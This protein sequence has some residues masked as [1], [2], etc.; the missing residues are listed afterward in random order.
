M[1]KLVD[2]KKLIR[3]RIIYVVLTFI[4]LVAGGTLGWKFLASELETRL[5]DRIE[6]LA[7]QGKVFQC[8]DQRVEG[9]P[10]RVGLFCDDIVFEDTARKIILKAG[11]FRSAA[12][13]YQPGFIVGEL[14]S[15][16]ELKLAQLGGFDLRWKLARSSTRLSLG[17]IRSISVNLEDFSAGKLENNPQNL[18]DIKLSLLELHLRAEGND[19]ASA[20]IEVAIELRDIRVENF[21]NGSFPVMN[22]IADGIVTDL[23]QALNSGRDL[24]DWARE[25]GLKL[26]MRKLEF[27]LE[28]GGSLL[29]S[30]PVLIDSDGLVSGKLSVEVTGFEDLVRNFSSQNSQ[31]GKYAELL[32]NASAIFAQGAENKKIRLPI[33]ISRGNVSAGFIPLG[34]IPPLY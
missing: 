15:P 26:Q 30:G 20:D 32:Q 7:K 17:G 18:P 25:N 19:P 5:H 23:N 34:I 2:E 3:R 11:K 8:S 28:S 9:F 6:H 1:N 33:Q 14:D 16:A 27:G 22:V 4:V 21:S 10:F 13:F 31:L 24:I 12:Q 29:A